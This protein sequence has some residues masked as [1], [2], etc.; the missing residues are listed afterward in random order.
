MNELE[1]TKRS[2]PSHHRANS[3]EDHP[4]PNE[5]PHAQAATWLRAIRKSPATLLELE[6]PPELER[7]Y[8]IEGTVLDDSERSRRALQIVDSWDD[9]TKRRAQSDPRPATRRLHA[10]ARRAI[11]IRKRWTAHLTDMH[12]SVQPAA[13]EEEQIDALLR[14]LDEPGV[15]VISAFGRDGARQLATQRSVA[16]TETGLRA[17]T[18]SIVNGHDNNRCMAR[19]R[20]LKYYPPADRATPVA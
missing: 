15:S 12:A 13:L 2:P 14:R 19:I 6:D 20:A 5:H 16:R 1:T 8:E 18:E 17:L 9:D 7:W 3:K 10:E 11:T 4:I